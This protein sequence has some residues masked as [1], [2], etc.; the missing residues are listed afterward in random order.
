M[1]PRCALHHQVHGYAEFNNTTPV[2]SMFDLHGLVDFLSVPVVNFWL[3][4]MK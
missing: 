3:K 4:V 1:E 2:L